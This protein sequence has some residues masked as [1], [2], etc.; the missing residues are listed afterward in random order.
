MRDEHKL[1][2]LRAVDAL[3]LAPVEMS[4]NQSRNGSGSQDKD[5]MAKLGKRQQMNRNFGFMS[6]LGFATTCM[7]TWEA[8]NVFVPASWLNYAATSLIT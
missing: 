7:G 5:D 3:K 6:M 2:S 8:L 4:Q 1:G